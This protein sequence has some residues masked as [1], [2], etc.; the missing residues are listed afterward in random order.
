MM[1]RVWMAPAGDEIVVQFRED[2]P[3]IAVN[4]YGSDPLRDHEPPDD[5]ELITDQTGGR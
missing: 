1:A 3:L 5:Y 2:G 4:E